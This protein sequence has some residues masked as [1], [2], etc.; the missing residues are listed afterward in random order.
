MKKPGQ[1][2]LTLVVNPRL[3]LASEGY[4]SGRNR[5]RRMPTSDSIASTRSAGTRPCPIQP[6][7]VPCDRRPSPR[8]SADCPPANLQAS[9]NATLGESLVDA[10]LTINAQTDNRVNAYSDNRQRNNKRMANRI[11]KPSHFWQR[12]EEVLGKKWAP[13]NTNS[14]AARLDMSQGSVHRWFIGGQDGGL[15][16]LETALYLAREAGVCVEWLLD[17]SKPKFR[18]SSD[19][20][21]VELFE[22]VE[23]LDE[24]GREHVLSDARGQRAQQREKEQENA[25]DIRRGSSFRGT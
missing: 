20:M 11:L 12:L 18:I 23:D 16:K 4:K 25:L 10:M 14:L 1:P 17:G 13:L 19:P 15:P 7:T 24:K 22:I 9:S 5:S 6:D 8:A 3:G 2:T 21:L